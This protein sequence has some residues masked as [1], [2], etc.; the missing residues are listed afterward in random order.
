MTSNIT[1]LTALGPTANTGLAHTRNDVVISAT[2]AN[3]TMT[4]FKY[5]VHLTATNGVNL[6]WY[7]EQNLQNSLVFNLK[8][9]LENCLSTEGDVLP[10]TTASQ[11]TLVYASM[12]VGVVQLDVY[13]GYDVAGVFT[14]DIGDSQTYSLMLLDGEGDDNY[15]LMGTMDVPLASALSEWH[16]D[17]FRFSLTTERY[18]IATRPSVRSRRIN[19]FILPR[20][21]YW[22]NGADQRQRNSHYRAL[23]WVGDN[24]TYV[25]QSYP[26]NDIYTFNVELYDNTETSFFGFSMYMARA[27]GAVVSIPTGLQNFVD[28]GYITELEANQTM[29]YIVYG[30]NT[31]GD[32]VTPYYGYYI[33]SDCKHNEVSL[34]WLNRRGGWDSFAFIKKSERTITTEKKRYL[35]HKGAYATGSATSPFEVNQTTSRDI[36]ERTPSKEIMMTLTT[37]WMTES[38][39]RCLASL[40]ESKEVWMQDTNYD[41]GMMIPVV[42]EDTSFTSKR[43]RNGKKYNQTIKLKVA[44]NYKFPRSLSSWFQP[45]SISPTPPCIYGAA[46]SSSGGSSTLNVDLNVQPITIQAT[47]ATGHRYENAHIVFQDSTNLVDGETYC[48]KLD[49]DSA[50]P[51]VI[52]TSADYGYISVGNGSASADVYF[53]G[54]GYN[55]TTGWQSVYVNSGNTGSVYIELPTFTSGARWTGTL[56]LTI[57]KISATC[58]CGGY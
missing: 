23:T 34:S 33:D 40:I 31:G 51:A 15:I 50:M 27:A 57:K 47:S 28:G 26:V 49:W 56:T 1:G 19:W 43:E 7:I 41:G 16:E 9:V 38:E 11:P 4:G 30:V 45:L 3:S 13:C 44:T 25:N 21:K 39:Y 14:E 36:V 55:M 48:V 53:D 58:Q 5:I 12:Y 42:I 2:S 17:T 46:D 32:A 6:K 18:G 52:N 35:A 22:G 10:F 8:G 20:W 54:N 37:D 29:Y 24:A